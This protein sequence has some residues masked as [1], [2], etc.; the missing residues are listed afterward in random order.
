MAAFANRRLPA[1]AVCWCLVAFGVYVWMG[2][3]LRAKEPDETTADQQQVYLFTSFEEPAT[4][5]LRFLWSGDGLQ[6]KRVPGVFMKPAAGKGHLMRDPS[7]VQGPDGTYHLVWTTNWRGDLGFG[8]ASS[9]DLVHWSPQRFIPVMEHEPS[10]VNVWAPELF[11]DSKSQDFIIAWASTIPG[12]YPIREEREDNNH[13]MYYTR[14]KDFKQFSPAQLFC[15]PGFSVI[16]AVI[17]PWGRDEGPAYKLVLKDNTRP[18]L[19]LR[20]AEGDS[21]TGPWRNVTKP[22]TAFK[23]EGPSVAK[24]G[25]RW[26]IYFDQYGDHQYRAVSTTDFESFEDLEDEVQFP[27]GH[28]HGTVLKVE[29]RVL[30]GLQKAGSEQEEHADSSALNEEA[31][32]CHEPVRSS[33]CPG[34]GDIGMRWIHSLSGVQHHG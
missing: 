12:R 15:E 4:A 10:T 21:P 17:V 34:G 13:R 18:V 26:L 3:L 9:S 5:G 23:T 7:L 31:Q 30:D 1:S 2:S 27:Q 14:T 29:R 25:D 24:V 28:K 8:Y 20:V 33:M 6:W 11:Y 32:S 22:I 16:D 19:A